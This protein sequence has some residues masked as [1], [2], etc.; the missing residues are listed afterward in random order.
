MFAY[1]SKWL[2]LGL[3]VLSAGALLFALVGQRARLPDDC[4]KADS[5]LNASDYELAIEHYFLCI[6]TGELS[7]RRL[8]DAFYNLGNAYS[9]KENY[10]QAVRDYTEA[11]A[12][13][14][15]HAWAYN[16]RCWAYGLLRR[17]DEALRD[18]DEALRLLPEQP[19]ILDSRALAYWLLDVPDKARRDLDRVRELDPTFPAWQERFREFE[20]MF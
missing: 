18:C 9:A 7:P 6:D 12:L 19:E 8:A 15:N 1:L 20:G 16:N 10:Y 4:Q 11:I 2:L 14:P 3:A 5:A 17:P 13:D